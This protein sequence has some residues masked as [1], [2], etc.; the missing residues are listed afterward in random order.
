LHD[1]PSE[2]TFLEQALEPKRKERKLGDSS[3]TTHMAVGIITTDAASVGFMPGG[4]LA[5]NSVGATTQSL[6]VA[7]TE[8]G[9]LCSHVTGLAGFPAIGSTVVS[10]EQATGKTASTSVSFTGQYSLD[11]APGTCMITVEFPNGS[12]Q[13]V[14]GYEIVRGTASELNFSY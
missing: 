10:A 2:K 13:G 9:L 11:L 1:S 4:S 14:R 3:Y 5:P 7:G 6:V 12:T 8:P